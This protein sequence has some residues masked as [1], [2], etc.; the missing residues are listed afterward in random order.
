MTLFVVGF[1]FAC[2]KEPVDPVGPEPPPPEKKAEVKVKFGPLRQ[3]CLH[4]N[5]IAMAFKDEENFFTTNLVD[6]HF[7]YP[8]FTYNFTKEQ[9]EKY[10][11]KKVIFYFSACRNLSPMDCWGMEVYI[12]IDTLRK[13]QEIYIEIPGKDGKK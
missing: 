9:A 5:P 4:F 10:L 11:G 3:D 12:S 7:K 6:T 2:D 1:F 8:E 13:T